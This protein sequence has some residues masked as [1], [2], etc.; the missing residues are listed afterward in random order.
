MAQKARQTGPR[1][2]STGILKRAIGPAQLAEFV[3]NF[4]DF[5]TLVNFSEC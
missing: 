3:I 4:S 1:Q 2:S 5:L